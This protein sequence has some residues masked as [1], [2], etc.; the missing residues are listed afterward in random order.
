MVAELR[1]Q[2]ALLAWPAVMVLH[3]VELVAWPAVDLLHLAR[4]GGR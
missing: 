3:L 2:A 1:H 4:V